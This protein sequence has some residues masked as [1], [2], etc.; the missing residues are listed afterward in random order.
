MVSVRA[1]RLPGRARIA[2]A[3]PGADLGRVAGKVLAD[4]VQ[5][6]LAQD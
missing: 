6:D 5:A 1:D 3:Q 2:A 4:D